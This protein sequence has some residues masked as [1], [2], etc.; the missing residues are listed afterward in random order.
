[1]PLEERIFITKQSGCF[2][3][4]NHLS[5]FLKLIGQ[6]PIRKFLSLYLAHFAKLLP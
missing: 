5:G 4:Q 6:R 2:A 1:M 3:H